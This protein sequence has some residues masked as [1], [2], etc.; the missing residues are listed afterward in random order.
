MPKLLAGDLSGSGKR[1]AIAATRFNAAIVEQLVAGAL[2]CLLRHGVKDQDITL[3][4]LPGAWELPV[5]VKRLAESKAYDAVIALGCVIR[6]E[7]PHFDY[8]AG[9]AAKGLGAVAL[10]SGVPVAFGVLTTD[11]TE[12]AAARAG[13]KAGN[14]GVDAAMSALEMANLLPGIVRAP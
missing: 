1:F 6:G 2:D 12:Q 10:T 8:V 3:V 5:V 4:R 14:K 13:L 11:T 7:T 9:E